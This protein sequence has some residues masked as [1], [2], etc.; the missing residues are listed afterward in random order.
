MDIEEVKRKRDDLQLSIKIEVIR[1]QKE[2]GALIKS[3]DIVRNSVS[4]EMESN[5]LATITTVKLNLEI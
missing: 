3:I 4:M 1:F 5:D 2:T